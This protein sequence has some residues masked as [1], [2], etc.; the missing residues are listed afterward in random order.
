[1]SLYNELDIDTD[2]TP[3]DIK[4]AFRKLS[5]MYHPDR[6]NGDEEKYKKI[7]YAYQILSDPEKRKQYDMKQRGVDSPFGHPDIINMMRG[8]PFHFFDNSDVNVFHNGVPIFMN[9][10]RPLE[11]KIQI[12][13]LEAYEGIHKNIRIHRDI[14]SQGMRRKETENVYIPIYE[15]IDSNEVIILK[16]YGHVYNDRKGDLKIRIHVLNHDQFIRKG[17][18]LFYKK[19]ITFKESL[20]GFK[21]QLEHING[22]QFVIHN[23][24]GKV[25]YNGFTKTI[26]GLGMKRDGR[27]GDLIIEF[28]VYYPDTLPEK[29]IEYLRNVL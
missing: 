27:V 24:D 11:Q 15:G 4:K 3:T 7:N 21:F 18:H 22:K 26:K 8:M 16:E 2:A 20:C 17:M 6:E 12:T 19:N 29:T 10:V 23:N 14:R 28:T 13:L 9:T 5:M 25:I 1:M